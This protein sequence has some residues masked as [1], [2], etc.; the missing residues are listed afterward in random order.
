MHLY[1]YIYIHTMSRKDSVYN[2]FSYNFHFRD[3]VWLVAIGV[4]CMNIITVSKLSLYFELGLWRK[5]YFGLLLRSSER[6]KANVNSHD[7]YY[8]NIIIHT[9]WFT[10]F[11]SIMQLFEIEVSEFLNDMLQY[12]FIILKFFVLLKDSV[13]RRYRLLL[14]KWEYFLFQ[15]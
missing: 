5:L 13:L 7:V 15:L 6:V 1:I 10:S 8:N 9:G 3:S 14:F 2:I 11:S 4:E 12:H